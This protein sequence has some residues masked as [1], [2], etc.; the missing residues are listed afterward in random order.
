MKALRSARNA[1]LTAAARLTA[2]LPLNRK[3]AVFI[4]FGGAGYSDNP[5]AVSEALHR[6]CP[7]AEIVW[8]FLTPEQ[9]S[10]PDYVK[11]AR[12]HRLSAIRHLENAGVWVFNNVMPP[13]LTKRRGQFYVQTWHGDRGFKVC[14]HERGKKGLKDTAAIDVAVA[15]S[16]H[17]VMLYEDAFKYHG[18]I[19]SAGSPRDDVLVQAAA[20]DPS[21]LACAEEIRAALGLKSGEK[22]LLYAPTMRDAVKRAGDLLE[23]PPID[24]PALLDALTKRDGVPWRMFYRAHVCIKGI[25]G[26][27]P[28]P[29]IRDMG[30]WEDMRDLLLVSDLLITDYSSSAGDFPLTGKPVILYQADREDFTRHSRAFYFDIDQSP[31][32]VARTPQALTQAALALTGEQAAENDRAILDFFQTSEP[33]DASEAVARAIIRHMKEGTV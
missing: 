12:I 17:A 18:D 13:Y 8:L 23:A 16:R 31:F 24:F 19:L 11:T 15:G 20:G 33:G 9:R 4:S 3:K 5:R 10:V 28:D 29:R 26:V 25:S 1:L 7:E 21:A 30:A 27:A 6:L 32:T 14:L 2:L 22:V